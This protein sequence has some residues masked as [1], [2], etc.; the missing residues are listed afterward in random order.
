MP[1]RLM[2]SLKWI[3]KLAQFFRYLQP[4]NQNFSVVFMFEL[5][6]EVQKRPPDFFRSYL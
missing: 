1:I 4:S 5:Y 3:Y 6:Q 2:N